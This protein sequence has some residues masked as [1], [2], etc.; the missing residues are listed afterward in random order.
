MDNFRP[1]ATLFWHHYNLQILH[2][3]GHRGIIILILSVQIKGTK[4]ITIIA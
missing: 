3:M 4:D 1:H 2:H